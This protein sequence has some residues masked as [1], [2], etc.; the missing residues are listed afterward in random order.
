MHSSASASENENP[1]LRR[2][3][4]CV[5]WPHHPEQPGVCDGKRQPQ[6]QP[7]WLF[8]YLGTIPVSPVTGEGYDM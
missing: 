7:V 5:S 8:L 2:K 3:W 1:S 6:Q 4:Q